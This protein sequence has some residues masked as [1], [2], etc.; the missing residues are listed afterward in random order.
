MISG[1]GKSADPVRRVEYSGVGKEEHALSDRH[2]TNIG[3]TSDH[4]K[5]MR[6]VVMIRNHLRRSPLALVYRGKDIEKT[7]ERTAE[8]VKC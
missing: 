6:S 4:R 1:A 2:R 7:V 5:K 8:A 3:P